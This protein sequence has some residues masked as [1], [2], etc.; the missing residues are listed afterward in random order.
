MT[1]IE[2]IVIGAARKKARNATQVKRNFAEN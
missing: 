1:L 2:I